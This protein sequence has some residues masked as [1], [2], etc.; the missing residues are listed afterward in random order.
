MWEPN[1]PAPQEL[2]YVIHQPGANITILPKYRLG[3]EYPKTYGHFHEPEAEETY[4]VLSGEAGIL[5]QKG[6]DLLEEVRL[7]KLKKGESFT[8]PKEY[9]HCLVNLG[10]GPVVT[11]DDHDPAKFD[12]NY[13]P[14]RKKHGFAYYLI[15]EGG[16]LKAI[17]NPD[18]TQVP[19]LT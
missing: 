1:A 13:E 9:A 3:R 8:V 12:N 6:T 11:L 2:Y 5:L 7:V 15:E 16:K 17:P 18:Y 19:P 14:I 10:E 4:K